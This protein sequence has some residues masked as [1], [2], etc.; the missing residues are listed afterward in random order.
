M[1]TTPERSQ[2]N[3]RPVRPDGQYR[4][5]RYPWLGE[6]PQERHNTDLERLAS[7]VR[8]LAEHL[9]DQPALRLAA[10]NIGDELERIVRRRLP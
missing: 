4:D 7:R 3:T 9:D 2:A 6:L 5:R 8:R 1:M 10:N